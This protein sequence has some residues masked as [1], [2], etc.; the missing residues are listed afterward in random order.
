MEIPKTAFIV[1]LTGAG[2]SAESGVRTFR[3]QGGLWEDHRIEDVA[4]PEGFARDPGL[5]QRFYNARRSQLRDVA[6]NPAHLALARLERECS[7]ELMVVTQNVDD[8]HARAGT[9]KLIHMH[10]ELRKARCLGCGGVSAWEEDLDGGSRCPRCGRVGALRPH[11]VWFG[12]IP[13]EME[14]IFEAL[15]RCDLFIAIGTSGNVYPAAGFVQAVRPGARTI[16]VNT[17]RSLVASAFREHRIGKAGGT[18][19]CARG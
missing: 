7:G 13:L 2:I 9:R 12:E 14:R 18:A 17:E 19:A 15:E 6:P 4:T 16:E 8:L 1:V 10:G 3:D 5:V 11:I